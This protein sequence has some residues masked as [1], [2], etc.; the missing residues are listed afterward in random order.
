[1]VSG[2]DILR[3]AEEM[4]IILK[5]GRRIGELIRLVEDMRD[6]E[7]VTTKEEGLEAIREVLGKE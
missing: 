3:A 7:Y 1:M 5:P 2:E 6:H 4:G